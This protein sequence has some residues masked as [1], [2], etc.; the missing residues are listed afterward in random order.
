MIHDMLYLLNHTYTQC[1]AITEN[2]AYMTKLSFTRMIFKSH[3][4]GESSFAE[5]SLAATGAAVPHV[6]VFTNS[7]G[8]QNGAGMVASLV[9]VATK[10]E[11]ALPLVVVPGIASEAII[12][13]S[14]VALRGHAPD[15]NRNR[16][17]VDEDIHR[18]E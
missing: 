14:H 9:T 18:R 7:L 8:V 16:F 10:H 12:T 3:L 6:I 4:F 11:E 17:P 1:A 5:A 15:H 13:R 2:M